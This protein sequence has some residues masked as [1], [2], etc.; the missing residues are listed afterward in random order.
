MDYI[1]SL[2]TFL[3]NLFLHRDFSSFDLYPQICFSL[4]F[5][6]LRMT[7]EFRMNDVEGKHTTG[8]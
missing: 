2:C 3:G 1:H 6:I 7:N 5:N 4:P 8:P